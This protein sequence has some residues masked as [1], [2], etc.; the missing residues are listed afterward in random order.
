VVI[1]SL[2]LYPAAVKAGIF[3]DFK[4][5]FRG[6]ASAQISSGKS[7]QAMALPKPAMNHDPNPAKGGADVV[8]ED[9]SAAKAQGGFAGEIVAAPKDAISIYVVREGDTLS[10]IAQMFG[11]S[12]NTII[13]ANDL[14]VRGTVRPGQR[15]TIL[16]VTGLK[17][18]V[19]KGD[20]LAS[21]AKEF[22][23]DADEIAQYNDIVGELAVGTEILIPN[24]ELHR[25]APKATAAAPA[26]GTASYAG[27]YLR[28][29]SGGTRTQGIHG[30]NGV[31]LA[32]SIG[33]PVGA[34]AA[35]EVIIAREGGWNGG[36]GSYVVIRHD[37][38]TQTLYGHLSAVHV[39]VGQ[40]VSRG[41]TIGAVGNSGR[42]TGAHL[43]FEIRGGPRNP[44]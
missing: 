19:E 18:T 20:T 3:S 2:A 8:I 33:T 24:G 40:Y 38:G 23:G 35:G 15:L 12:V 28:P 29:I 10:E 16:P 32:A 4:D 11:V 7:V 26:S 25:A 30:Y 14:P 39:G 31:D 41:S 34:S 43:H 36:Y 6:K 1:L 42:S 22:H 17:Y 44:F 27:Y 5:V 13:W 21:I 37:N 9:G